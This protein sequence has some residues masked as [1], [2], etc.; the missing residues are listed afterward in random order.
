MKLKAVLLLI[1]HFAFCSV[2][3]AQQKVTGVVKD[4]TGKVMDG[5]SIQF[6]GLKSGTTTNEEGKFSISFPAN[7]QKAVL[8]IT[9]IGFQKNEINV[10]PGQSLV[11]VLSPLNENNLNDVIVVGYQKQSVRKTTS[12]I[13]V[14][15]GKAIENLPAPSF[16]QLLQGKV[17]GINIQNFSGEPGVRNTFTVRGNSTL[18]TDL[19]N[20]VDAASTLS[21]PLYIVDGIPLSINDLEGISSSG[22]NMLAGINI[23]DIESIIVQKDA[24][25]T[26][27]WGSRGANGVVIIK[28]K[29]GK[30]GKPVFKL[31]YYTGITQ[32]PQLLNTVIGAEERDQKIALMNQYGTYNQL[33]N[34]PQVLSDSLNPAFNNATDWQDLFYRSGLVNN[35]DLSISAGT[36]LVNY[37]LG[38][39]YYNEDGIIRNTGFKRYA[40]R[41]NFDF[42]IS[43]KMNILLN[44][45]KSI[46]DRKRG[47]GRGRDQVTPIDGVSMPASFF[48][49]TDADK[50]FYYG[51]YDKQ[52]DKNTTDLLSAYLQMNYDIVKGIQYSFQGSY[53]S[54]T[55]KRDL[56]QPT[57]ITDDHRSYAKS[58][59]GNYKQTYLA[60]I[61][62]LNK[63]F[64]ENKHNFGVVLTQS[65]QFDEKTGTYL[66]GYNVPDDNIQVVAGIPQNDIFGYSVFKQAGLLSF[67]GQL[68]YD[69]KGKYIINASYRGDASSRFGKDTKWG[70]FPAIS[71]S[72]IASEEKFIKQFQAI[73]FLKFRASY[74]LSG[75]LPD[76]FYAPFNI[77][78]VAQGTYNGVTIATPSNRK[79]IALPNLTWNK[80][81]QLNVGADL[82]LFK[83]RLNIT[84]DVYRRSNT[85]PISNFPFP[86]YTGYTSVTYNAPVKIL[87]E[88]IDLQIQT[89]NLNPSSELQ[90]TTNFN[91]SFNKNR[92]A[93][94]PN[95]NRSFYKDSRGFNE[96]LGYTVGQSIYSWFQMRYQGVYNTAGQI[97][98]NPITGNVITYFK[99]NYPVKPGFPI[100]YDENK[101]WDVW[102]DEDRGDALGDL[103]ATGNPNP[104]YTGGI[105]NEF[106]YKNFSLGILGTFTIG[107]DIINTFES[108]Q[109][110]NVW[111]FGDIS[112]FGN[113]RLPDLS[114]YNYWTPAQAK[115]GSTPATFPSLSPYGPNYYQFLPFS[116]LW[117][118]N[119]TYLRIKNISLGYTINKD[120]AK[121]IGVQN[122]RLY[123]ILDNVHIFQKARVPDAELV[124]PQGEYSGAAYPIPKKLTLGLDITF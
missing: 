120:L 86:F 16:D 111:N 69:F 3:L 124:S 30:P 70:Y 80:S 59:T 61:I 15:T 27:T 19:N 117:N 104:K 113:Q 55:D 23:N 22:T 102:S 36:D 95:G 2:L 107:R 92:L 33:A 32:R 108:N 112:N 34:I 10:V 58:N 8:V 24:A 64:K 20:G 105:Y 6:K 42:K 35:A 29:R 83:N 65:I 47:L 90:W 89:R 67:L 44:L 116:T 77:W 71:A 118:D 28:T 97:P 122:I 82:Y 53:S 76:D 88:G 73:S 50:D 48:R 91:I 26:A 13:Q 41:G 68:S 109:F 31:S 78:D 63:S 17:S 101:D 87:N 115:E 114:R 106:I 103:V 60:N 11:S 51:K 54:T 37:R 75:S 98:V 56:F 121:R 46:L 38:M 40:F 4:K 14:I 62:T 94:L 66:E 99:T 5:V 74:G 21:T 12:A 79:P 1:V 84:V 9:S 43:K 110:S 72:W 57:E 85:N 52:R 25:A 7:Q 39:N 18:S 45:S 96:T 49:L 81:D 119:G 93:A 123:S 100:F